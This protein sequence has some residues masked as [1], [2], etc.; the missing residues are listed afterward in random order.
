MSM[1][2][3]SPLRSPPSRQLE[4]RLAPVLELLH[5]QSV[6]QTVSHRQQHPRANVLDNLLERQQQAAIH[7]EL[8]KLKSPDLA[9]LLEMLTGD[10]RLVIWPLLKEEVAG[11]VLIE[12]SE[13]V[14]ESLIENTPAHRLQDILITLDTD[15]LSVIADLLTDSQLNQVKAQLEANERNWLEHTLGFAEGSVGEIMGRECLVASE[16]QTLQEAIELVRT[17]DELPPQ[18]DKLFIVNKANQLCGVLPLIQLIRHPPDI[19]LGSCMD[20]QVVSFAATD[21]AEEAAQAFDRYDLVSA[22][23]V[24]N[25]R[26]ILGRLTVETIMD[27]RREQ[28]EQQ[29]LAKEGLSADSDLL[30]PIMEGARERW[31]WLCINLITAFIA[32]R[33]ISVFEGTIQQLVALAALMPIVASVGGNTGN[34]TAALVI[35]GLATNRIQKDNIA[36]IYRKELVIGLINGIVWG[37]VMG[38]FAWILYKNVLLGAVMTLAVTL[39]LLLAA[40]IGITVP[41]IL[42][43]LRRDPAMGSSVILTFATDSMGFFLFL[44]LASQILV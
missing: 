34:Q 44:G 24:D 2:S 38:L 21:K 6:V 36:Y 31:P 17:A 39:N 23:V 41:F 32:T 5:R 10:K 43:Q 28:A 35:R 7:R 30:G 16:S 11:E 33:F 22:P 42:N 9:H 18:T 8:V 19:L 29:A 26:R 25:K 1:T 27:H 40:L 14:A 12:L 20:T 15:E 3:T 37:S 4:K 13:A